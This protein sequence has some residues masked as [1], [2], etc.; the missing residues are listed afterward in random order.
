MPEG[1]KE[2][3]LGTVEEA[4]PS[5]MVSTTTMTDRGGGRSSGKGLACVV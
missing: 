1:V 5:S 3:K 4:T 2:G